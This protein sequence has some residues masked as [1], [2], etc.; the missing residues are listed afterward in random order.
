[1]G[2]PTSEDGGSLETY[3]SK[4]LSLIKYEAFWELTGFGSH[5]NFEVKRV[6][7]QSNPRMG[8]HLESWLFLSKF[9]FFMML[10]CS[11]RLCNSVIG[12]RQA[13]HCSSVHMISNSSSSSKLNTPEA[14]KV[15]ARDDECFSLLSVPVL[16]HH[17]HAFASTL[18]SSHLALKLEIPR[19]R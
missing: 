12:R 4:K 19:F 10:C 9:R 14:V 18:Q 17:H 2:H 3:I 16:S 15:I 8:D 1:M 5:K 11:C 6:V 13:I 7:D